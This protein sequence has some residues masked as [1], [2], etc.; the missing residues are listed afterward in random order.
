MTVPDLT[1]AIGLADIEEAR[2]VLD[3]VTIQT[4]MEESRWLSE[5]VGGPVWLKCENLQRTGSFKARGAYV[6][7]SRLTE[8]ER[9]QSALDR[10]VSEGE[11][12]P[13]DLVVL[14]GGSGIY[15]GRVTD[16]VRIVHIP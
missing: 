1:T 16:T 13:G 4:P 6:R 12:H 11:V 14:L 5:V 10:A 15:R 7:I 2:R 9:A 8:E 3:G